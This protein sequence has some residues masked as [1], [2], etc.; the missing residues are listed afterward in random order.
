VTQMRAM[1]AYKVKFELNPSTNEIKKW[2]NAVETKVLSNL[3]EFWELRAVPIV[4]QSVANIFVTEGVG[5]WAPLNPAY[6]ARK[7]RTHPFKTILRRSDLYFKSSTDRKRSGNLFETTPKSMTYGINLSAFGKP[8]PIFHELGTKK[9]PA[10]PVWSLL[11]KLPAFK[12]KLIVALR[13]YLKDK[14]AVESKRVFG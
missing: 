9:M 3:T 5:T 14:V 1:M 7:S 2:V 11:V 13:K 10:R 8:Y 6:A 12:L 4:A